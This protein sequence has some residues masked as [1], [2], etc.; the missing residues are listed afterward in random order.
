MTAFRLYFR[1]LLG[2]TLLVS[3]VMVMLGSF[4]GAL[5]ILNYFNH[6]EALASTYLHESLPLFIFLIPAYLLGK[7][8]NRPKWVSEVQRYQ[9]EA[10]KKLS[11]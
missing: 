2:L 7:F 6:E 1:D 5:A 3:A 9:L 10:E 8:I 11:Q 4:F